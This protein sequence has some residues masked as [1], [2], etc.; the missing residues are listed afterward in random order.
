MIQSTVRQRI[1]DHLQAHEGGT[2]LTQAQL[3]RLTGDVPSSVRRTCQ[4]LLREGVIYVADYTGKGLAPRFRLVVPFPM[5][6]ED[7]TMADVHAE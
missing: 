6:V 2:P 3:A 4:S 1:L 5:L 7:N